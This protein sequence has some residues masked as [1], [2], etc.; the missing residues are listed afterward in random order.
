MIREKIELYERANLNKLDK[1]ITN[2]EGKLKKL[3]QVDPNI[4][5]KY[6]EWEEESYHHIKIL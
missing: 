3:M 1:I 6:D 2:T 5:S 4:L